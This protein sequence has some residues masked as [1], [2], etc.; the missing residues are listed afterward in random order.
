MSQKLK[1]KEKAHRESSTKSFKSILFGKAW[2]NQHSYNILSIIIILALLPSIYGLVYITG[3]IKYVY[4]HTM[5]IPILLAGILINPSFAMLVALIGGLLLSPIMPFDVALGDQQAFFNW[6]YRLIIFMLLGFISGYSSQYLRKYNQDIKRLLTHHQHT[7]LPN[8]K[9][10]ETIVDSLEEKSYMISSLMIHNNDQ[11]SDVLGLNVYFDLIIEIAQKIKEADENTLVIHADHN[12]LW[13][14]KN[15]GNLENDSKAL[16]ECIQTIKKINDQAVFIDFTIGTYHIKT[17]HELLNELIF[18]SCDVAAKLAQKK[19]LEY[20][21]YQEHKI[22]TNYAF[23]IISSFDDALN[24]Q[25][26]HL[27]YQPIMDL[28]TVKPVGVEALIRWDHPI[29]G[30][31]PPNVFIPIIEETKLIHKLTDWVLEQALQQIQKFKKHG[32]NVPISINVST[33]NLM[34]PNF[35]ERTLD[36]I[37]SS[38]ISPKM[39]QLEI[40]EHVLMKNPELCRNVLSKFSKQGIEISVDDFGTGYSSLAYLDTFDIDIVKLDRQFIANCTEPGTSNFIVSSTIELAKNL[41]YKVVTEGIEDETQLKLVQSFECC[42]AQGYYFAKP[43]PSDD[44]VKWYI[45][46]NDKAA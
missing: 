36:K 14:I 15:L 10:L 1:N 33:S 42:F 12:K 43:M 20:L 45:D 7:H 35:Y 13:V 4:S 28:K 6:F 8:P 39:I 37:K 2:F 44:I 5:Y 25:Q 22:D 16:V 24:E 3:G 46:I 41:G 38:K 32:L 40:T 30:F 18:R 23:E 27:V 31:I 34:H 29:K 19:D 9:Y 17:K 11:I 26:T 21:I